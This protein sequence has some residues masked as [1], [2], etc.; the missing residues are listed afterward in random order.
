MNSDQPKNPIRAE[1]PRK[2]QL[3]R[4]EIAV[5]ITE[6]M[7]DDER[8]TQALFDDIEIAFHTV[9]TLAKVIREKYPYLRVEVK[10]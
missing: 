1:L 7:R 5:Y 9:H 2:I 6:E 4:C 3:T 10:P 8:Q